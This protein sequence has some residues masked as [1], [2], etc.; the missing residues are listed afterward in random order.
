MPVTFCFVCQFK[1]QHFTS[2][3]ESPNITGQDLSVLFTTMCSL[4][5]KR[6]RKDRLPCQ[7]KSYDSLNLPH[8]T[9]CIIYSLSNMS[10]FD[11]F[12]PCLVVTEIP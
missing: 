6:N 1:V 4:K 7:R 8:I 9:A 11:R 3:S 5:K 10:L 2:L 12:L